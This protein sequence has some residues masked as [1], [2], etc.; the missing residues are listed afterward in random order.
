MKVELRDNQDFWGGVML[1][2]TGAVAVYMARNYG[3][4]TALRMGPGYFPTV[5]GVILILFGL[6]FVGRSFTS[7]E[8]IEGTWSLRALIVIPISFVLFGILMTNAGLVAALMVLI[9][10]G[11]MATPEFRPIEAL[12]LAI[13]LTFFCIVI[14]VWGIGLPY[15]LFPWSP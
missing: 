13:G 12:L 1:I 15:P 2:V 5:L 7:E 6:F 9:Y 11:S 10:G 14:F 3:F 4:G 8:R